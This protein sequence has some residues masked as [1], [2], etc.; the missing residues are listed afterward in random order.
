MK[1]G[2]TLAVITGLTVAWAGYAADSAP[3]PSDAPGPE[4][5]SVDIGNP[6][7]LAGSTT[8]VRPGR[9]FDVHG[10]GTMFGLHVSSDRGRFVYVRKRGDFDLSVQIADVHPDN[11]SLAKGGL[12]VRRSL[13][14]TDLFFGQEVSTNEFSYNCD[15]YVTIYRLKAGGAL[16]PVDLVVNDELR[17][18]PSGY[19]E[20]SCTDRPRPFP[21]VWLR[22][23][24]VGNTY[25][26]Y[27]KEAD[28]DWIKMGGFTFDLG[29]NPCVGMYVA[30]NEHG[31]GPDNGATVKFRHLQGLAP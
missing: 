11:P 25:T 28:G 12:M 15:Q 22:L 4:F 16:D 27:R 23:T 31:L 7:P 17:Y 3:K 19:L 2:P 24:R 9:D 26:G 6:A 1:I 10:Y 30:P 14:P 13:E 21:L 18:K 5:I 8:V 29:D 20:R